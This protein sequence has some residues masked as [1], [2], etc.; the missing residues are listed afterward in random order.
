MAE[1]SQSL[2]GSSQKRLIEALQANW[3]AEM[4]GF[5]TY[6]ALAAR[7]TD[8][9]RRSSLRG[10]ARAEKHHA[11]LWAKRL[12]EVGAAMPQYSGSESGEADTLSA[13]IGG[14][15]LALR[16]LELEESRDIA[17][18]G[19]QLRELGD[20]PSLAILHEVVADEQDHYKVLG[21]RERRVGSAMPSTA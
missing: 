3:Q 7:E 13:R 14:D 2:R 19:R 18:Y 9:Q 17:K 11:E 12:E 20:E 8:P 5:H 1:N 15:A 6:S 16:R 4:S 10:L 21:S